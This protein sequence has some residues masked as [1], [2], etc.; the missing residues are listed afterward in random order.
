M[1]TSKDN[2][3]EAQSANRAVAAHVLGVLSLVFGGLSTAAALRIAWLLT[4]L[5]PV[6]PRDAPSPYA[7]FFFCFWSLGGF[8][9]AAAVKGRIARG[10]STRSHAPRG[11]MLTCLG[12][13]LGLT[14]VVFSL[15]ALMAYVVLI[16]DPYFLGYIPHK[17]SCQ[18]N[19]KEIALICKMFKNDHPARG[20]PALAS[21]PGRLMFAD[22]RPWYRYSIC[23]E[24]VYYGRTF[25]CFSD[26][27][28][29][30]RLVPDY[31]KPHS[32]DQRWIFMD[33]ATVD[34]KE[35]GTF[36][37]TY[38][39]DHSYFY[40]GY[41]VTNDQ[42]MEAFAKAYRTVVG[43]EGCFDE[44]LP[45][46]PGR[47]SGGGNTLL[48]LR[49]GVEQTL[50]DSPEDPVAIA[51]MKSRIPV[52]IERVGNHSRPGGNVLF[53]D[54]HVDFLDYPGRWPMTEKTVAILEELD[55][56]GLSTQNTKDR[57]VVK[58]DHNE[59]PEDASQ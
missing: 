32:R 26:K 21:E 3:V 2:E 48:R 8:A 59:S 43:K 38:L 29:W 57:K 30:A 23:N 50:A 44:D 51:E 11:E 46:P 42:E 41:A 36:A 55:S 56:L 53:L 20:F 28:L 14:Y 39:D 6:V 31:P 22:Q 4:H 49:S 19:M 40:L 7:L 37:D 54:D 5:S 45:T 24:L 47:G 15:I 52:L 27:E 13:T 33:Y 25:V 10:A 17:P 58:D 12:T 35:M 16:W 9:I 34:G 1:K 18:N